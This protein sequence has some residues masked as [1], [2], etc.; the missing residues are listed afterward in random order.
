M[1]R[2]ASPGCENAPRICIQA[3]L[4]MVTSAN[5]DMNFNFDTDPINVFLADKNG[6]Q[7]LQAN[8]T[9]LGGT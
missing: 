2:K 7:W 3:H 5:S 6:K 4:D 8:G 1:K 9:T